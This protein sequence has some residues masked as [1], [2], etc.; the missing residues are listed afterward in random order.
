MCYLTQ[1]YLQELYVFYFYLFEF[2]QNFVTIKDNG[3]EL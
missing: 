1:A 2:C 3:L